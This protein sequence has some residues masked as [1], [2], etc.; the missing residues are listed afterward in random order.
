MN[1]SNMPYV[2]PPAPAMLPHN[3]TMAIIS[4][5]GGIAGL[6]I[7]PLIGSIV[8]LITGYMA[9]KEI[10]EGGGMVTGNGLATAGIIMGYISL[11]LGLCGCIIAALVFF[12]V[13]S[14]PF[15][16]IPFMVTPGY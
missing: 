10:R 4:L 11:A 3:S 8:A 12:G 13:V 1:D 6:T 16:T 15:F 5:I 7:L 14:I 2:Q 9:K